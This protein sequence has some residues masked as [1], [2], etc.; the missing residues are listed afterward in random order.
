MLGYTDLRKSS[1]RSKFQSQR[2]KQ[3]FGPQKISKTGRASGT[4]ISLGNCRLLPC[5]DAPRLCLLALHFH[6]RPSHG[7]SKNTRS[8]GGRGADT[9]SRDQGV[10][11]QLSTGACT[12]LMVLQPVPVVSTCCRAILLLSWASAIGRPPGTTQ[13]VATSGHW[14]ASPLSVTTLCPQDLPG[15]IRSSFPFPYPFFSSSFVPLCC[16][17]CHRLSLSQ[18]PTHPFAFFTTLALPCFRTL[19]K[20]SLVFTSQCA[21]D[22]IAGRLHR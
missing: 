1:I 4:C 2:Q 20:L 16:A 5:V 3:L 13:N 7:R 11:G 15:S 17:L 14:T 9:M 10:L 18:R 6:A 21:R 19:P 22:Q 12:P 8:R